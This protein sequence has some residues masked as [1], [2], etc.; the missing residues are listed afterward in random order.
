M[1]EDFFFNS[2]YI[3][4]YKGYVLV[5]MLNLKVCFCSNIAFFPLVTWLIQ[6]RQ[7]L[8][9][10]GLL[11]FFEAIRYFLT[12]DMAHLVHLYLAALYG[13]GNEFPLQSD[14]LMKGCKE[15]T[16]RKLV[17]KTSVCATLVG[18]FK[19]SVSRP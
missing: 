7:Y 3:L 8:V 10:F 11:A 14:N 16:L 19:I 18:H 13:A 4:E 6:T 5:Y 12:S 17:N 15:F 9:C 2:E 1:F